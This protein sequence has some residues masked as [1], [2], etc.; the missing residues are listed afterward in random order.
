MSHARD[1]LRRARTPHTHARHD[2]NVDTNPDGRGRTAVN[3]TRQKR[4][5]QAALRAALNPRERAVRDLNPLG[6]DSRAGSSPARPTKTP[7]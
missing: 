3:Q 5:I 7:G 2:T 1:A 6:G 4:R